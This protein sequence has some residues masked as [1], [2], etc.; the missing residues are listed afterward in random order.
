MNI[1]IVNF[2]KGEVDPEIEARDDI[3][4]GMCRHLEN[5]IPRIYGNVV[6]R[7]GTKKIYLS[8]HP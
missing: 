5:F 1:E 8:E 6:R 4:K 3:E 2:A 7:P